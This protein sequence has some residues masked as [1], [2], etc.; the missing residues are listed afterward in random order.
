MWSIHYGSS[1]KFSGYHPV[2]K[3]KTMN[4]LKDAL[5]EGQLQETFSYEAYLEDIEQDIEQ[6]LQK[7]EE[8]EAGN[9]DASMS[10]DD[11]DVSRDIGTPRD[12]TSD[13]Q[14]LKRPAASNQA[15]LDE[16][17]AIEREM[18]QLE[19]LEAKVQWDASMSMSTEGSFIL[20]D[21][22]TRNNE[23]RKSEGSI[24]PLK[25][26]RR[27]RRDAPSRCDPSALN[28]RGAPRSLPPYMPP[29]ASTYGSSS[30][31]RITRPRTCPVGACL[32][33]RG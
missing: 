20:D 26:Q 3:T 27:T 8:S 12:D 16:L 25:R 15:Y 11:V 24:Q 1:A 31:N 6:D 18:E 13:Q 7:L 30:S 22:T 32:G 2:R 23:K 17:A 4:R 28:T 19:E 33:R 21:D 5:Q 9:W 29:S 14:P 10:S